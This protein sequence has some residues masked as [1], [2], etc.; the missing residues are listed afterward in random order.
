MSEPS[1]R[2]F[3]MRDSRQRSRTRSHAAWAASMCL[4]ASLRPALAEEAPR[5]DVLSERA[6]VT[7]ALARNPTLAAAVS[8]LRRAE[9]LAQAEE[10][11]YAFV[12]GLDSSATRS[13]SPSLGFSGITTAETTLYKAGAELRRHTV[14]GTDL[15]LRIEGSS[16][17]SSSAFMNPTTSPPTSL[18]YNQGPG[19]GALVK[20][21]LTQP[22]LRGAGSAVYHAERDAARA[23]RTSARSARDQAASQLLLD[24]LTAYW[25]LNY[26]SRAVEIQNRG[27]ELAK[28]QRDETALRVSSGSAAPVDVLSFET[29]IASLEED[30]ATARADQQKQQSELARLIGDSE[31]MQSARVDAEA[32]LPE[33]EEAPQN[34]KELTLATSYELAQQ[35]AAVELATVQSRTA[36]ESFRPK[37]DL[38]AYVQGQGLGNKAVGPAMDQLGRLSAV[39]AHIGLTYEASLDGTQRRNE[40]ERALVAIQSAK[41][42]LAAIEQRLVA[43][44][45]KALTKERSSHERVQLADNTLAIARRQLDAETQRFRTGSATA[46]QVRE[47]ENSVRSAELRASRARADWLEA[48]LTLEHLSGRLLAQWSKVNDG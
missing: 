28:A 14:L 22:L 40:R 33:P 19:Y 5:A 43:D 29:S 7:A 10:H 11:R 23:S 25:E 20:L 17:T 39:S 46:L 4:L 42:R 8:D 48:A 9:L 37:L 18:T 3:V 31:L 36:D 15:T 6:V 12:L 21:G 35:R 2:R 47:S 30:L 1:Q 34:V 16:Q 24:V 38:D 27:L 45:D 26:A 32:P 41:Q 44:V 13:R